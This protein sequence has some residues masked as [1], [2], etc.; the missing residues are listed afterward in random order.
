MSTPMQPNLFCK[1][2]NN[3][4][5]S[6]AQ[7]KTSE[8]HASI[9]LL[10][11]DRSPKIC[12][13]LRFWYFSLATLLPTGSLGEISLQ[14]NSFRFDL[15]AKWL[16]FRQW[17]ILRFFNVAQQIGQILYAYFKVR[18]GFNKF[19]IWSF[20]FSGL[21]AFHSDGLGPS[22][23][24]IV[25]GGGREINAF[26]VFLLKH[27]L[28]LSLSSGTSSRLKVSI[29]DIIQ[30]TEYLWSFWIGQVWLSWMASWCA[31]CACIRYRSS[32]YQIGFNTTK[33]RA[34]IATASRYY[35]VLSLSVS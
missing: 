11:S 19:T 27:V 21:T 25:T 8:D 35:R 15:V 2:W 6:T 4:F 32:S 29:C 9:L 17:G 23:I 33:Y 24:S 18:T 26:V 31:K 14:S 3:S 5:D 28:A 1:A 7:T 34:S 12:V 10:Q 16:S 13:M 30:N 22:C 20:I